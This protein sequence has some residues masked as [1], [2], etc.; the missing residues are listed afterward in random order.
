MLKFQSIAETRYL[1]TKSSLRDVSVEGGVLSPNA[2]VMI[3]NT[4]KHYG[5][6]LLQGCLAVVK[7]SCLSYGNRLIRIVLSSLKSSC[8]NVLCRVVDPSFSSSFMAGDKSNRKWLHA[9]VCL[10]ENA[11]RSFVCVIQYLGSNAAVSCRESVLEGVTFVTGCLLEQISN[12]HSENRIEYE[13]WGTDGE[14][15]KLV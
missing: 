6:V 1:S 4:I 12:D 2:A 14:C 10:R 15:A 5:H 11:I 13:H 8:S 9:A 3:A 7:A